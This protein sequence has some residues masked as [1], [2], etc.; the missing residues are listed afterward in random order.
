MKN[1]EKIQ[2]MSAEEL[3]RIFDGTKCDYCIYGDNN[4][5]CGNCVKSIAA[6]LEEEEEE[7]SI[8]KP[9]KGETYY[10]V[11]YA[12]RIKEFE[13]RNLP[14]DKKII[15]FGNACTDKSVMERK[16]HDMKLWSLLWNFAEENNGKIDWKDFDQYKYS[17]VKDHE[18]GEFLIPGS[19]KR[20][21]FDIYFSSKELALFAI[22]EIVLPWE[23]GEMQ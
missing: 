11:N 7:P 19:G 14:A 12:G 5:P 22:H 13:N 17:I 1:I 18:S 8:F 16:V 3:A 4:E 20:K 2:Q 6:W 10:S 23:R 15:N 21:H 9:K